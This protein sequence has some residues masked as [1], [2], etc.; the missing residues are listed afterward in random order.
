MAGID[1]SGTLLFTGRR[2]NP[3]TSR[4]SPVERATPDIHDVRLRPRAGKKHS[5]LVDIG[6][7]QNWLYS[8][9]LHPEPDQLR[10]DI[11]GMVKRAIRAEE[12][13]VPDAP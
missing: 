1:Q 7:R 8:F 9:S 13:P 12:E 2:E 11:L 3:G 6:R 5:G 10:S 4:P